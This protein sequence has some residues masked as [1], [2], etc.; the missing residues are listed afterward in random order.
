MSET[1]KEPPISPDYFEISKEGKGT[2]KLNNVPRV[3][4]MS[5][6]GTATLAF[7]YA[8]S[9]NDLDWNRESK[10]EEIP[11]NLR[12]AEPP[13]K[14]PPGPDVDLPAAP[15][16]VYM[17][18]QSEPVPAQ[19]PEWIKRQREARMQSYQAALASEPQVY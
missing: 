17:P 16:M 4:L 3:A 13:V 10:A 9:T 12:P 7:V 5:L 15:N 18:G 19:E 6:L 2:K 14:K 8:M 1:L 11:T